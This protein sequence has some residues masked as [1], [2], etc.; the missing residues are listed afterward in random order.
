MPQLHKVEGCLEASIGAS[1]LTEG[2][3]RHLPRA[4]R[5]APRPVASGLCGGQPAS[6]ARPGMAGRHPAGPRTI[7]AHQGRKNARLFRHR[8]L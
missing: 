1:G 6:L 4:A 8:R 7:G 3:L 2:T 5:A